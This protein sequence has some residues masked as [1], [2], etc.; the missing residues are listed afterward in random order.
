MQLCLQH[1]H[2]LVKIYRHFDIQTH[3]IFVLKID[4]VQLNVTIFVILNKIPQETIDPMCA[5]NSTKWQQNLS[6]LFIT[7]VLP[8]R[9]T[10]L[11]YEEGI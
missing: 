6:S 10:S 2:C 4:H 7:Q 9:E 1:G 8:K 11:G 3:E 5:R